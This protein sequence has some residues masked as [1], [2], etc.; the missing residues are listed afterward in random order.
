MRLSKVEFSNERDR[1]A[2]ALALIAIREQQPEPIV[3]PAFKPSLM[4]WETEMDQ[5][6]AMASEQGIEFSVEHTTEIR[7]ARLPDEL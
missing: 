4:V 1:D 7:D 2:A 6:E 3:E 5:F